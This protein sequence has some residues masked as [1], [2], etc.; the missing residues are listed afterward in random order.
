[1]TPGHRNYLCKSTYKV[2]ASSA[3]WGWQISNSGVSIPKSFG[4][5]AAT[6]YEATNH[7]YPESV[8]FEPC[9]NFCQIFGSRNIVSVN[10]CRVSSVDKR[11]FTRALFEQRE[12]SRHFEGY[13][14]ACRY[15]VRR[16]GCIFYV[17]GVDARWVRNRASCVLPRKF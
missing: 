5:E 8:L 13:V 11:V 10:L 16:L 4:F 1:M 15:H 7:C 6:H 3:A 9:Q 17:N 12:R 14:R 2:A